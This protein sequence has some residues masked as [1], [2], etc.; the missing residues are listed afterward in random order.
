MTPR[1][2]PAA[3]AIALAAACLLASPASV[4]AQPGSSQFT[5]QGVLENSGQPYSGAADVRFQVYTQVS[6]GIALS[7]VSAA[8]VTV[9]NG[10]FTTQVNAAAINPA[11]VVFDGSPRFLQISV[12]IPSGTGAFTDLAPRQP[13]TPAPMAST[14]EG[15][16]YTP[17]TDARVLG[18]ENARVDIGNAVAQTDFFVRKGTS[19]FRGI[20]GGDTWLP[21]SDGRAYLTGE[22]ATPDVILRAFNG[23]TYAN[24]MAIKGATGRVGIGT[25]TPT[26]RFHVADSGFPTAMIQSSS[27]GGSW[28][29]LQNTSSGGR[30]WALISSGSGNGEGAGKLVISDQTS[31]Q[32]RMVLDSAGNLGIGTNTPAD[33][34]HVNGNV[35]AHVVII[36]G[37]ADV[38]E[39]YDVAP[40]GDVGPIPGMVVCID[41]DRVG[42]LRIAARA[43]DHTVAGIISGADNV[44]PGLLLGQKGTVAD[45]EHPI[46]NV[47]RVW[48]FVDAD[49]GGPVAPGDL[50][51]TSATPGHAMKAM[52]RAAAGGATI[53]KAMSR[54]EKGKGLVL[55]LVTLQ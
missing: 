31:G 46:A 8:T 54:L 49:A 50:L 23:S 13:I 33:R 9:T 35:R 3:V 7:S 28:L 45:G 27:V 11:T 26:A 32:P 16:G 20:A 40:A 24:H 48:C 10:V 2:T 14:V 19:R 55:V 52:D 53:G 51:T 29:Q 38:A 34:L 25:D 39:A 47:G 15:L 21:A 12:R 37:G 41:P 1:R 18:A 17:A 43:Y 36:E 42:K 5:Y 4:R 30:N 44:S 6:G 22:G